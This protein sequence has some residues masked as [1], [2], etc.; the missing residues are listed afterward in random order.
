MKVKLKARG[1]WSNIGLGGGVSKEDLMALDVLS[2]AVLPKMILV[3]ASKDFSK[4]LE[5]SQ[6]GPKT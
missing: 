5:L 1:W 4:E 6:I 3:V 2:S